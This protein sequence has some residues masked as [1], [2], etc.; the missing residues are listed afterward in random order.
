MVGIRYPDCERTNVI[1][2]CVFLVRYNESLTMKKLR[3]LG[4]SCRHICLAKKTDQNCGDS[5]RY[6]KNISSVILN[7]FLT[8]SSLSKMRYHS[9]AHAFSDVIENK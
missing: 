7:A 9:D 3:P 1:S 6:R 4:R 2:T 5:Y 8:S